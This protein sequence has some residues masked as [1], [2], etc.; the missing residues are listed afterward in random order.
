MSKNNISPEEKLLHLIKGKKSEKEHKVK[1]PRRIIL[2]IFFLAC[3][4]LLA[5]FIYPWLGSEKINLQEKPKAGPAPEI[6]P[7]IKV[8]PYEYYLQGIEERK[9]FNNTSPPRIEEQP[10]SA[11]GIGL[12]KDVALIGIISGDNPQAIIEDKKAQ[13]TYYLNK[14][15]F[16]GEFQIEEIK[17]GKIILNHRGTKY[18]LY[19]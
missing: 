1:N 18:E 13:K 17:E 2:V 9:I 10:A 15:Q 14:G 5:A 19:L 6:A 16:I 11:A 4:Y 7:E 12:I 3:S 8:K